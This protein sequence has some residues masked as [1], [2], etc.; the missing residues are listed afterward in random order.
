MSSSIIRASD[1]ASVPWKNGL[2]MTREIAVQTSESNDGTFVWRVSVAEVSSAA[3]F[4]SFPGIDRHIVLLDGAGFAMT[5][6]DARTHALDVPFVPFAF[7]GEAKISV[8]LVDGP[9]RDFNLMVQRATARGEVRVLRGPGVYP[10]DVLDVL[11]YAA[12]GT[13]AMAGAILQ[14]GDAVRPATSPIVPLTLFE[15]S[16]ALVVSIEPSERAKGGGAL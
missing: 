10:L 1:C 16:V 13:I 8:R 14:P 7:A 2:G 11:V 9:T 3:P 15:G 12:L 5:L 6:D 4:S